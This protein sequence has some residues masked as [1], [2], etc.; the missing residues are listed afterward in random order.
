MLL[1]IE[2]SENLIVDDVD[3]GVYRIRLRVSGFGVLGGLGH[4]GAVSTQTNLSPQGR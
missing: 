2:K 3:Q 4:P 1:V